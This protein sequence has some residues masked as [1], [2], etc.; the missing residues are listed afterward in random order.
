M[1][2][3]LPLGR[4]ALLLFTLM[5][6]IGVIPSFAAATSGLASA[7]RLRIACYSALIAVIALALTVF[8]G[9]AAMAR[10]GTSAPSMIMAAGLI[11]TLTAVRNLLGAA[12]VSRDAAAPLSLWMR[13]LTPITVPGII[14]PVA[15]AVL[16]IFTT[17]FSTPADRLTIL[18]VSVAMM[19][20]DFLAMLLSGWFMRR[21]GIAPLLLLGSVFGVLQVALGIEML[22]SGFERSA[23]LAG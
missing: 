3:D 21:I 17:F 18:A 10:V 13:A 15:V 19:A 14:T 4:L 7:D 12:P 1:A 5:G 8:V 22:V 2:D 23:V 20:L 16:I 11:L 9:T 6:P